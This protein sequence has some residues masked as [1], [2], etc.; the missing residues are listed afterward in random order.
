MVGAQ[1]SGSV[2]PAIA[3]GKIPLAW[4]IF[5][6]HPIGAVSPVDSI[7]LSAGNRLRVSHTGSTRR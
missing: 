2:S 4:S 6:P 5:R 7:P 3:L 1:T